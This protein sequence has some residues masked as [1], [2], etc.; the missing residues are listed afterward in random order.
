MSSFGNTRRSWRTTVSPPTPESNTPMGNWALGGG[1]FT[2]SQPAA[3]F[4]VSLHP[5][6]TRIGGT[7]PHRGHAVHLRP[8]HRG[9]TRAVERVKVKADEEIG[10]ATP[11][12]LRPDRQI[13]IRV[14][15]SCQ[16]HF[17]PRFLEEARDLAGKDQ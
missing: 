14:R 12:Q 3:N 1:L 6:H 5:F 11:G 7:G 8:L 17:E 15:G 9:C 2:W 16:T 10:V 13:D 4:L